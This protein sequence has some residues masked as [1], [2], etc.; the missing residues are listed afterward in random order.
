M[1]K[2][3][4]CSW[5]N[6]HNPTYIRYHDEEWGVPVYDDHLLGEMLFLEL[7]HSGLSWECVLMKREALRKAL[8]DF[9]MPTIAS[10][11]SAQIDELM[12]NPQLI[13]HRKK[14]EALVVNAQVF[15]NIQE[16][17]GS[18]AAYLWHWTSK[19]V[20]YERGLTRSPLSDALAKD[21]KARGMKY[22][23][24]IT[25]YAYLQAVGLIQG[26]DEACFMSQLYK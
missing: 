3:T 6:S 10:F 19:Q 14:L 15:I 1:E 7:L 17:W 20:I 16:E 25:L 26:H 8:A 24:S 23:G 18:F 21:L 11:D 5:V 2:L 13:R 9:D 12:A 4:R 22:L